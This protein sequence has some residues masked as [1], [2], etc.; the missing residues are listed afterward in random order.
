MIPSRFKDMA[1]AGGENEESE[2]IA[3]RFQHFIFMTHTCTPHCQKVV[4]KFVKVCPKKGQIRACAKCYEVPL[5]LLQGTLS[6]LRPP[7]LPP[8]LPQVCGEDPH[9][10]GCGEH[11]QLRGAAREQ[12]EGED[13]HIRYWEGSPDS[14]EWPPHK[15]AD[16]LG[17][18][19]FDRHFGTS[20]TKR[21]RAEEPS[22]P[23]SKH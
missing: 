4:K 9:R 14:L 18:E 1:K 16:R 13:G 7:K 3:K 6:I 15:R 23:F 2:E 22:L 19:A 8:P 20:V 5:S 17:R 11:G 12:E 10:G 21:L